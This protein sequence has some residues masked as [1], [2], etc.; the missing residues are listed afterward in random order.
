MAG[1]EQLSEQRRESDDTRLKLHLVRSN[2]FTY[3]SGFAFLANEPNP[4]AVQVSVTCA[5]RTVD[6]R[7]PGKG[8]CTEQLSEQRREAD[9]TRLKLHLVATP[10]TAVERIWHI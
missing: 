6:I 10:K 7:L 5:S 1:T 4:C 2:P 9:D 8:N 3:P